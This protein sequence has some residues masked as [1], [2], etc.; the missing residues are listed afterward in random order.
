MYVCLF[1]AIVAAQDTVV[2]ATS[3]IANL[4]STAPRSVLAATHSFVVVQCDGQLHVSEWG[5][6]LFIDLDDDSNFHS[7]LTKIDNDTSSGGVGNSN[8]SSNEYLQYYP[9]LHTST[10]SLCV[11]LLKGSEGIEKITAQKSVSIH[12]LLRNKNKKVI[13]SD[14]PPKRNSISGDLENEFDFS[15][16]ASLGQ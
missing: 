11:F 3:D 16:D 15:M 9:S 2:E 4:I 1:S 13:A 8:G 12:K 14:S 5:R 10:Q 7:A 6:R